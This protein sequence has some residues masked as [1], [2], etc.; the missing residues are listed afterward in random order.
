MRRLRLTSYG[1]TLLG[2]LTVATAIAFDLGPAVQLSGIMLT[3]AGIVKIIVVYI[4]T[5]VAGLGTDR[6]EPIP[7]V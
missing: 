3:W 7:P 4:W 5:H 6:H 1:I 2:L